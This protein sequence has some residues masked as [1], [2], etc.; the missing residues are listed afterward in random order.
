MENTLALAIDAAGIF[1]A[2]S[3]AASARVVHDLQDGDT[4]DDVITS[5]RAYEG[6]I[7][8]WAEPVFE[9]WPDHEDPRVLLAVRNC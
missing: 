3:S 7:P 2:L 5:I 9:V 8:F 4:V 1:P 6:L